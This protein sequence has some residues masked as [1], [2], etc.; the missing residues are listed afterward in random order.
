MPLRRC[1]ASGLFLSAIGLGLYKI[2][3]TPDADQFLDRAMELGV[4]HWDTAGGYFEGE[5]ER[6]IG[7]WFAS[8]GPEKRDKVILSTKWAGPTGGGR[9]AIRKAVDASLR[10]LQTDYLD[11]F[12]LHN[13]MFENGQYVAPIDETWDTL[14][15]LVSQGNL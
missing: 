15:D 10:R 6:T 1:G 14:S 12:M 13:P 5:S 11:I 8:R 7:K 9:G 2:N 3:Q 4:T